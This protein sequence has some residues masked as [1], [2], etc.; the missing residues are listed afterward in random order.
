MCTLNRA[1][2]PF[3]PPGP[4]GHSQA[5]LALICPQ[6]TCPWPR[7]PCEIPQGSQSCP[8]EVVHPQPLYF[9]ATLGPAE[10]GLT[11][12]LMAWPGLRLSPSPWRCSMPG[13]G[14]H[15]IPWAAVLPGWGGWDIPCPDS[16]A[17]IPLAPCPLR[18][19][20]LQCALM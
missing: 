14:V 20:V 2:F 12:G 15:Q 3:P 17:Q 1:N 11:Y 5:T 13:A 6:D 9:S 7:T 4:S 18:T 19:A 16:P 10:L 8:S